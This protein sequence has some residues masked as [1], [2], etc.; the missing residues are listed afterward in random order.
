LIFLVAEKLEDVVLEV[1]ALASGQ[2]LASDF[3]V[4]PPSPEAGV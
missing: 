2:A 3:S 4:V 1:E